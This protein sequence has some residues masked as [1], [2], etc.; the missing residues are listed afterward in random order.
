MNLTDLQDRRTPQST[1][2]WDHMDAN[3]R[4]HRA[5]R[6]V[7]SWVDAVIAVVVAVAFAWALT[8]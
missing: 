5:E 4:L 8:A 6:P 1:W 2:C 7:P 3:Q